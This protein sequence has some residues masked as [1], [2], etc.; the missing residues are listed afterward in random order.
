MGDFGDQDDQA[1]ICCLIKN[2]FELNTCPWL[3][4]GDFGDYNDRIYKQH[5]RNR[6]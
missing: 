2:N 6:Y 1:R 5:Q 4:V 3:K